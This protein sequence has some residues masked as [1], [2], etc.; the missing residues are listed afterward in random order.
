MIVSTSFYVSMFHTFI[1]FNLNIIYMIQKHTLM[2]K[3]AC[4]P[5]PSLSLSARVL[6]RRSP[7]PRT[8]SVYLQFGMKP[9]W[10]VLLLSFI[11][12]PI[13]YYIIICS[14]IIVDFSF[15]SVV[16]KKK[17]KLTHIE[18]NPVHPIIIIGDDRYFLIVSLCVLFHPQILQ[19]LCFISSQLLT[20]MHVQM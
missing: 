17:T 10:N 18:F 11:H 8:A 2:P 6:L 9:P 16:H 1:F 12:L 20:S 4:F 5:S 7:K 19:S 3:T 15:N 14:R 13:T